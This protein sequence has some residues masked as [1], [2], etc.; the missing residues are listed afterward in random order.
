[1]VGLREDPSCLVEVVLVS[2]LVVSLDGTAVPSKAVGAG[3]YTL[4]LAQALDVREDVELLV[5]TR[6]DDRRHWPASV[7]RAEA[8]AARPLR[9]TWEQLRLPGLLARAR[10]APQVHHGPHYTMPNR[11]A[12]AKVVTI[13]DMTFVDHPEWHERWKVPVFRRAIAV[14]S[15]RASAIVC[16]SAAT[17]ARFTERCRPRGRVFVAPHG[18]DLDRFAEHEL[19]GGADEAALEALGVRKPYVLFLGTLEPRKA[20]PSLVAA[21]DRVA[22]SRG[23]VTLVLAGGPGWGVEAVDRAIALAT[24]GGRVLRT[25]YVPD[26]SVAPL[27]RQAGAVAYPA[28]EEG[29]GLPALEALACGA[30]LVTTAGTTMAEMAGDAAMVV[31]P[32]SVDE[33]AQA[34]SAALDGGPDVRERRQKGLGVAARHTWAA[35][36]ASHL[37]AYRWAAE[38]G[39]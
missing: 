17:A 15:R 27:L 32:G 13:H 1:M 38:T 21:F 20:V 35:S 16:V 7:V 6:R 18:V 19:H 28:L 11:A 29:F 22:A 2:A 39:G 24:N 3:R 34:L 5:W 37:E 12:V 33:L 25:G 8:P 9:L 4:E 30:P 26:E 36:A 14:A 31:S 23:E 10:P